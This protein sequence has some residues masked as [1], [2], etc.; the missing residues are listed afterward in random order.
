MADV[1]HMH[2]K[3]LELLKE[4]GSVRGETVSAI[5]DNRFVGFGIPGIRIQTSEFFP[6][7][8]WN[9]LYVLPNGRTFDPKN[10]RVSE[11][12]VEYGPSDLW[13]MEFMGIA[14][15]LMV[16]WLRIMDDEPMRM[17]VRADFNVGPLFSP[18]RGIKF[19]G[20]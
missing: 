11:G 3:T 8:E 4:V 1:I 18:S 9:G 19:W 2:P 5:L 12:L 13:L 14:K 16:P 15:K 10:F 17:F 6:V 7:E 20:G